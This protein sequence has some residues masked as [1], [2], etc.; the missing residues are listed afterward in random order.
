MSMSNL[1]EIFIESN[2]HSNPILLLRILLEDS[3]YEI[4]SKFSCIQA[5]EMRL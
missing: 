2:N 3:I 5:C 1:T 4:K